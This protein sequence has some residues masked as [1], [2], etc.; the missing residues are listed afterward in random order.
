M[1][2]L[3]VGHGSQS[4]ERFIDLLR[5]N[6]VEVLVDTRSKPFSARYPQ[7]NQRVLAALLDEAGIRYVF[8]GDKLGGRPRDIALYDQEGKPDYDK[9]AATEAY[10]R[11]IAILEELARSDET[12][13]IMC[14]ESDY[15]ECHR[16]KLIAQ[17]LALHGV[18]VRHI[19]KDG[20]IEHHP[21]PQMALFT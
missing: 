12:T 10:K 1:E 15:K 3:T 11:G 18:E 19:L 9:I 14:S 21:A 16:Y 4:I 7:F 2:I 5:Q 17:S 8:L 20:S 13:A 6:R